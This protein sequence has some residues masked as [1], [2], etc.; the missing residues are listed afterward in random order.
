MSVLRKLA[1]A[2]AALIALLGLAAG[3][4]YALFDAAAIKRHLVEQV[5]VKTGRTLDIAGEVSLSLWPEVAVSAGQVSLSEADGKTEFAALESLRV[6]VAVMPLLAG[7]VEAREIGI[8]GLALTLVKRRDGKLNIDDLT[9]G[10]GAAKSP[11]QEEKAA[12]DASQPLQLDI[13]GLALRD[14]RFTWR[15]EMAGKTTKLSALDFSTGRVQA[16]SAAGSLAIDQLKL[17]A[18]GSSGDDRFEANI[19]LPAIKFAEQRLATPFTGKLALSSPAMPMGSVKLPLSGKLVLDLGKSTADLTLDTQL[20]ASNIALKLAV[21]RLSP[22]FFNFDLN[23]DQLNVDHYLPPAKPGA[24]GGDA[25]A[26]G[27]AEKPAAK[28]DLSALDGLN[29]RGKLAVGQLQ[30]KGLKLSALTARL[31]A[32]DGRF[33]V[34]SMQAK[35]YGGSLDGALGVN[36]RGNVFTVRQNLSGIDIRPLLADL[37]QKEPLEGRGTV[38]LNVNT[39]GATVDALK[40]GLA[41]QAS[42]AL[43]DGAIRGVNL[44]KQLRDAKAL[45]RGGKSAASAP[46]AAEKTDFSELIATFRIASGVAHNEDLAMKSPFLRLAGAGDIDIGNS[47][48]D[49]LAKVSV[50]ETSKG[51][52]GKERDELRGITVPVRLR[53]PFDNLSYSLEAGEL[54][55]DAAKAK[56]DEKKDELKEKAG[57]KLEEK[58]GDKLKGLFGK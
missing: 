39:R 47:Q 10:D 19:E 57:K 15:D 54:L 32:A 44:A 33:D 56:L 52:E 48:I 18:R 49:Y 9:A 35:L 1:L 53:G 31:A 45:L 3:V 34:S 37:I 14:A 2:L 38:T 12:A 40:R 4:A 36:A 29:F 26:S 16:D 13:A 27:K 6:A 42:L 51:Q 58:L 41:G 25:G 5:A 7:K 17:A 55:K 46:D 23:I 24:A 43:K 30:A 21:E 11:D 20:D 22:L 28:I 8:D 50:V